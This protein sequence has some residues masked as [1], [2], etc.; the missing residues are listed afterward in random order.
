MRRWCAA[1]LLALCAGLAGAQDADGGSDKDPLEGWNRGVFAFNE[2]VDN[3][4]LKPVA[5]AYR[6][7]VPQLVRTGVS[8]FF[9]NFMDVWSAFNHLLQGKAESGLNM[10]MRVATN[11]VFGIGGLFDV[12]SEAGLERQAEDFGQTLGVW[13]LPSGPYLVWPLLG[14]SALR[15]TAALPLD[16]SWSAS[17]AFGGQNDRLGVT[18]L[19]LVDLRASLLGATQVLDDIALDKY[20]FVRDAYLTRRQS[21][22]HD[23]NPPEPAEE[24]FDTPEPAGAPASD[25]KR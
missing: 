7:V 2:A 21:L 4:V 13:G 9:G 8:N 6:D 23:G 15:E 19:Q 22:V 10:G 12:A 11:T 18:V 14:P 20:S 17:L 5:T 1:L 16:L 3:A 24:R 25:V